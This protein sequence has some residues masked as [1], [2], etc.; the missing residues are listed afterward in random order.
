MLIK[1]PDVHIRGFLGYAG[2]GK[3]QLADEC[4]QNAWMVMPIEQR[5]LEFEDHDKLW[6]DLVV[7][8]NPE[9]KFLANSP[10][11]PSLNYA[12]PVLV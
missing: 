12:S 2:W 11:D 6:Y 10:D 8:M 3:E 4:A 7:S 5:T 1:E 9:L